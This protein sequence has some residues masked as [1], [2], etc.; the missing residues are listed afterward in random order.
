M[1]TSRAEYRLLMRQDN[2]DLRLSD[3]GHEIGL[4]PTRNHRKFLEKRR[5]LSDEIHRIEQTR[6]GS[7]TLAQLLR[8]PE[9]SYADLPGQNPGLDKEIAQQVEIAIKYEGYIDRQQVEVEKLKSLEHKEIPPTFDY[10]VV[11]SLRL[12]ARQKLD[13]IRPATIGQAG[14]ISGVSPADVSILMVW[15]KRQALNGKARTSVPSDCTEGSKTE[16]A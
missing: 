13:K 7:E 5:M 4:L 6:C 2:A 8:R 9:V 3:L 14:R 1:F 11:P 16:E 12:E 10:A 15:L